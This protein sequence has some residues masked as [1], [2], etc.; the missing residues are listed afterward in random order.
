MTSQRLA[1]VAP[2][3][4]SALRLRHSLL[5]EVL[6]RGHRVVC[7]AP[8][9]T[10]REQ[11]VEEVSRLTSLGVEYRGFSFD[12]PGLSF[13]NNFRVTTALRDIFRE[14]KP[15][16]VLGYGPQELVIAALAAKRAKVPR[17]VTLCNDLP[18]FLKLI[19]S[20]EAG[21]PSAAAFKRALAASDQI[22]FHNSDHAKLVAEHGLIKSDAKIS[23]VAGKGVDVESQPVLELPDLAQGLVFLMVARQDPIRGVG[24]YMQAAWRVSKTAQA[25]KFILA[26]PRGKQ[27]LDVAGLGF[28]G[29]AFEWID[30][31]VE[32]RDVLSRAHVYVCPSHSE[33]MPPTVLEALAAGRPIITTDTPGCRETVDETVNGYLVPRG[34]VASLAQAMEAV[35]KRPDLIPTMARAS[36]LKAERR[37]DQRQVNAALVSVLGL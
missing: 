31:D 4:T 24:D 13:L 6:A 27:P 11:S 22:V 1:M 33:G 37:F 9:S 10:E 15:D 12:T 17:I 30:G 16:V 18:D 36:R 8:E 26:G 3:V 28:K 20:A 29:P 23:I 7:I 32:V 25:A 5:A 2:S 14:W 35:L 34:D 21:R 19:E